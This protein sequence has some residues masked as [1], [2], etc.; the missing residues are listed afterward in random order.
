MLCIVGGGVKRWGMRSGHKKE[1][2]NL[3]GMM[4]AFL[5]KAASFF[6]VVPYQKELH[7][8]FG[9]AN[10]AFLCDD[11]FSYF[12]FPKFFLLFF[13]SFKISDEIKRYSL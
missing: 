8:L 10:D 2:V 4:W 6:M 1:N 12:Y 13:K 11:Y 3:K 9:S 7:L 5:F